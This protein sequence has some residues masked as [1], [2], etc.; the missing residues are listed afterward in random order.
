MSSNK[1]P[2]TSLLKKIRGK[3]SGQLISNILTV[4]IIT[5]LVKSVA[6]FKE[7]KIADAYGTSLLVDTYL[8]AFLVPSFIQSV[9][10][11]AYKGA[12]I[13]NYVQESKE[14]S[15]T[16][17]FQTTSFIITIG[18]CLV[19]MSTTHF[20][21]DLYLENLFPGKDA[22]FYSLVKIQLSILL[23]SILFW[24]TS[25]LLNAQL[26][27]ANDF[28]YSSL[29][30]FF[31]P[32]VTIILIYGFREQLQ[33]K[34]LAYG[35]LIGSGCSFFYLL[36]LALKRKLLKIGMPDFKNRNTIML[37]KQLPAK[38][39]S[40]L[41]NGLNPVVDQYFS[42]KL[43]AGAIA[44]LN[45]GYKIPIVII[46]LITTT[47]AS[48]LLPHFSKKVLEGSKTLFKELL[49]ILKLSLLLMGIVS[50]ILI[51]FSE[52]IISWVFERGAFTASDTAIVSV[53]QQMYLIQLPFYLAANVMNIFLTSI[54]KNAFLVISSTI[55]LLL[56]ILLNY[57]LID[58]M[59]IK[60]LALATSLVTL[61]NSIVIYLYINRL[62]TKLAET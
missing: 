20:G 39:S 30:S 25:S 31:V 62:Q 37:L 36:V 34:T 44:S 42:G 56:N 28:F 54:N 12:F 10:L 61:C 18:V 9:F 32:L 16:K 40:S 49:K 29:N 3:F 55:S 45:Y 7:I 50:L 15:D 19:V 58:I 43:M 23:P 53:V 21:I 11:I 13:P 38:V 48:T 27:V 26:N 4:G 2:Q 8:I 1:K 33:E 51:I 57:L 41:I 47:I 59:G 17:T 52:Q 14:F 60:G 5:V 22:T 6:F 46:G 24:G 35:M